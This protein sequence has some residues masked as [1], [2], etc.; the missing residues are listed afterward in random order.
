MAV[1]CAGDSSLPLPQGSLEAGAGLQGQASSWWLLGALSVSSI[2][3]AFV[4]L[5][6]DVFA[7]CCT[8]WR[9]KGRTRGVWRP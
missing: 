5:L 2:V 1:R 9:R 8:S 4:A 7:G 6:A 3:T